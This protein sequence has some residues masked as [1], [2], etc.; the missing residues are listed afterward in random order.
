MMTAVQ[1]SYQVAAKARGAG[2]G[3]LRLNEITKTFSG[4]GGAAV[5]A[6]DTV[7]LD[8]APGEFITLLGPSG[9][10]KT[11]TLRIVAGF[12]SATTGSILLDDAP[13]DHLPPQRRQM[14]MVFQSYALFPHLTVA[15]NIGYGLRLQRRSRDE[16]ATAMNIAV[17]SMNLV[18]L[19]HRH[20]HELSGG[21]QQRV[22]LARALVVQPKVLL[23]DEPLSNLDAKLRGAM[24]AEIRR[25]QH[26]F[27]ITSLYVTHDQDEAMSM[28][29]R[30]VV[31]NKGR[32]EQ[33]A[34]PAEIYQ[35]PATVF[36]ADFIGRA[37]FVEVALGR[38][39][40]GTAEVTAFGGPMTVAAHPDVRAQD[41]AAFLMVR[42]E[43]ISLEP[44]PEAGN[45]TVLR[46]TFHGHTVDYDVETTSGTLSVTEAGP[47]PSRLLAAGTNVRVTIDPRKAYLLKNEY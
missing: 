32:V 28:S 40:A 23:F 42:P 7:S 19:E 2:A 9:C 44:A 25:I 3:R 10:G 46:S 5:T 16:I 27:G 35:R 30:I 22:A 43:T 31:M 8:V 24:R 1:A 12:E 20:P 45:G 15:Q 39:E 38:V 34:T 33:V 18:G 37:N 36:V 21:Q 14:S 26:M 29:D 4:R 17:T 6:V 13:V 41:N 47:D 11:T